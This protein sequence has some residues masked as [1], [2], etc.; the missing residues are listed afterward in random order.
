MSTIP[1]VVAFLNQ[2]ELLKNP[3]YLE[4]RCILEK[5]L[6]AN[7]VAFSLKYHVTITRDEFAKLQDQAVMLIGKSPV[8]TCPTS[9][10][11]LKEIFPGELV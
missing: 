8:P 7:P 6:L 3:F 9:S 2:K 11:Q 1:E 10:G 4:L 5:E